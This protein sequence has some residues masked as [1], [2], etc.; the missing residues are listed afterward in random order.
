MPSE[1]R[2]VSQRIVTPR[3]E[4]IARKFQ[5]RVLALEYGEWVPC[6]ISPWYYKVEAPW[7]TQKDLD[8]AVWFIFSQGR[9]LGPEWIRGAQFEDATDTIDPANWDE[10]G[11]QDERADCEA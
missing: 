6:H 4:M 8:E 10:F 11:R 9:Y 7:L 3:G 2:M 5:I 1:C